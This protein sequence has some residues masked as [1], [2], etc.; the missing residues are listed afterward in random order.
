MH[1]PPGPAPAAPERGLRLGLVSVAVMRRIS[2]RDFFAPSP[3]RPRSPGGRLLRR[4]PRPARAAWIA[5]LPALLHPPAPAALALALRRGDVDV[6]LALPGPQV[7]PARARDGREP[8]G[9]G[10]PGR[11]RG[12]HVPHYPEVC[13]KMA[14]FTS[15]S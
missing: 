1:V 11:L 7:D 8:L 10:R 14:H 3:L 13:Q 5:S 15:L 4:L 12:C 2:K 9:E 6:V